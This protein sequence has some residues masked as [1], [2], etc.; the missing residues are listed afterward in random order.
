MKLTDTSFMMHSDD[1]KTRFKAEYFQLKL[2]LEGLTKMLEGLKN[3]TL[4]FKP[5]CS[6]E[7]FNE[8][9]QCMAGYLSVLEKSAEIEN[10][11][12]TE[13]PEA[14]ETMIAS[15]KETIYREIEHQYRLSD[16]RNQYD[17]YIENTDDESVREFDDADFEILTERFDDA[18]DCNIPENTTWSTVIENYISE[19]KGEDNNE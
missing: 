15:A 1:F 10:I 2:R 7:I 17:A 9:V 3:N 16:A 14:I 18:C 8:Q 12:L 13:D 4:S 11:D 19:T 5:K 6:Y